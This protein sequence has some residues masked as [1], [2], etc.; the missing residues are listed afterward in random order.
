MNALR[1][2]VRI[3]VWVGVAAAVAGFFLPW[4]NLDLR[5]PSVMKQ[6]RQVA[7]DQEVVRGLAKGLGKVTATIRRGTKTVTG[8]LPSLSD[9]PHHVSGA[10]IPQMANQQNAKVA[11]ALVEVL[12][13]ERQHIGAKSYL[14]YLLPGLA[15]LCGLLLSSLGGVP[16]VTIGAAIL[17]AGVAGGGF[18]KL[19]TTN[20]KTLFIAIT[21][22]PGLW[23]SLWGYVAIAVAGLLR[24]VEGGRK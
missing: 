3:L 18:W 20:T 6:V 22:G 9:I 14:V 1:V 10:Q 19:L 13:N 21:I 12:M 16:A 7:G 4:A 15:L 24:G 23:L 17:C 5:E 2:P 11:A 8:D